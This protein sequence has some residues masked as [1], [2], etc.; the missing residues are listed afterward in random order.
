MHPGKIGQRQALTSKCYYTRCH[1]Y[2]FGFAGMINE[3]LDR[4]VL[5][6]L[7]EPASSA[8]HQQGQAYGAVYKFRY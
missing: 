5:T 8:R 4:I 1:C 7:A 3:T 2:C 6:Y